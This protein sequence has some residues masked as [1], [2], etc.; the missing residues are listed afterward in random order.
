MDRFIK[1]I[2]KTLQEEIEQLSWQCVGCSKVGECEE[3]ISIGK[4]DWEPRYCWSIIKA[5]IN[6]KLKF[7]KPF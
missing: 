1:T 3:Q 4:Q 6:G 5:A 7:Q 2:T